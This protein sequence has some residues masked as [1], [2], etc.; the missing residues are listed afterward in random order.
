MARRIDERYQ[1]GNSDLG[2]SHFRKYHD[3]ADSVSGSALAAGS[4]ER[5]PTRTQF[6]ARQRSGEPAASAEPLTES[7]KTWYLRKCDGPRSLLPL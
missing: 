1:S 2:P 6:S 3:L 4:P 5:C 7:A